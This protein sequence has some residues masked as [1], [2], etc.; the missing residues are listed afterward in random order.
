M[1]YERMSFLEL[2]QRIYPR[3]FPWRVLE[4]IDLE[5]ESVPIYNFVHG[6]YHFSFD[7]KVG[8]EIKNNINGRIYLI[9]NKE[10]SI[11]LERYASCKEAVIIRGKHVF[12][13]DLFDFQK[14]NHIDFKSKIYVHQILPIKVVLGGLSLS[15]QNLEGRLSITGEENE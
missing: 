9:A 8:K 12:I 5:I 4:P 11:I 15:K 3:E 7:L 6:D 14:F 1:K 2:A 13:D 10:L